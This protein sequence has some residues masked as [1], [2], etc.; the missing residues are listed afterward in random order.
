MRLS[1]RASTG[2]QLIF[3]TISCQGTMEKDCHKQCLVHTKVP[4]NSV[5]ALLLGAYMSHVAVG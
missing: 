4:I 2:P 5:L 1:I 3:C